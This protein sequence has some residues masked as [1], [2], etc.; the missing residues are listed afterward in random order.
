MRR[1]GT[2]VILPGSI[3]LRGDNDWIGLEFMERERTPRDLMELGI[4]FIYRNYHFRM[5]SLLLRGSVSN[6]VEPLFMTRGRKRI[7]SVRRRE[8]EH[9]VL[10]KM[11]FELMT[12][13]IGCTLLSILIRT[14]SST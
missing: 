4:P 7:Y 12:S 2:L 11:Q 8:S 1:S 3:R 6:G 14:N 10:D 5:L 9:V 13:S